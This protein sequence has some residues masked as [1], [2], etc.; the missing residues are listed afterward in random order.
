MLLGYHLLIGTSA[1]Q[2]YNRIEPELREHLAKMRTHGIRPG[3]RER[4]WEMFR[5]IDAQIEQRHKKR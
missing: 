1:Q 2:D 5:V 4:A 3:L